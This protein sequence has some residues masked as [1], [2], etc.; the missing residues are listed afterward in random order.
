VIVSGFGG[1][2]RVDKNNIQRLPSEKNRCRLTA[3]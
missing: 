2:F 1:I 3:C